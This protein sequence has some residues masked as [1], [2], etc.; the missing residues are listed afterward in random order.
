[1]KEGKPSPKYRASAED[2]LA[3]FRSAMADIV[4]TKNVKFMRLVA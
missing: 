4:A 3:M 1:L 2:I